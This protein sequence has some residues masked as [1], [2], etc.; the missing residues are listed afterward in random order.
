VCCLLCELA[1]RKCDAE[2]KLY[3]A[4]HLYK[5]HGCTGSESAD[6]RACLFNFISA[7]E[8]KLYT[9]RLF[10]S[11]CSR[12]TGPPPML[13]PQKITSCPNTLDKH[14]DTRTYYCQLQNNKQRWPPAGHCGLFHHCFTLP[15]SPLPCTSTDFL[16]HRPAMRCGYFG[17][18]VH[19]SSK[20]GAPVGILSASRQPAPDPHNSGRGGCRR[21]PKQLRSP[22][23]ACTCSAQQGSP[24]PRHGWPTAFLRLRLDLG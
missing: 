9:Q 13:P 14:L 16:A 12:R 1:V 8:A 2:Y 24:T 10:T 11:Q 15:A 7:T 21:A 23:A 20:L 18:A 19:S 17:A 5:V 22:T 3:E 4:V 6:R